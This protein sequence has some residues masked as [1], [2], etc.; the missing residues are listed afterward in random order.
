MGSPWRAPPGIVA[1]GKRT[2]NESGFRRSPIALTAR[3][4]LRSHFGRNVTSGSRLRKSVHM[5]CFCPIIVYTWYRDCMPGSW[6]GKTYR[7][8]HGAEPMAPRADCACGA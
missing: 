3:P 8:S 2:V 4:C 6:G 5:V 1:W 7:H